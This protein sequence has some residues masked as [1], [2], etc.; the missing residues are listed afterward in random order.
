MSECRGG[1]WGEGNADRAEGRSWVGTVGGGGVCPGAG[2]PVSY[3]ATTRAKYGNQRSTVNDCTEVI[4][5]VS[6][7]INRQIY[8]IDVAATYETRRQ[9]GEEGRAVRNAGG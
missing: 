8:V 3:V 4:V 6:F 9:Y 1:G 5:R 2:P 7:R